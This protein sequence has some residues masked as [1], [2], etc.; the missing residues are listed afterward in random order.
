MAK[1]NQKP[2]V[3]VPV[4]VYFFDTDAGGVVH[5]IAYLRMVEVARSQLAEK[6]GW[7]LKEMMEG[8]CPVVARTEIDYLRPAQLGDELVIRAELSRAER[9]KFFISF[10]I[11]RPVDGI[12]ICRAVQTMVTV[13]LRTGKPRPLRKD[14]QEKFSQGTLSSQRGK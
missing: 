11:N 6:L 8:E 12:L 14:W 4:K 3:Q 9:V 10:E 13:D 2:Y 7:P 1:E 5:N